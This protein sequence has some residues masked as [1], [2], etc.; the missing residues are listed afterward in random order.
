MASV[1]PEVKCGVFIEAK[2]A[3]GEAKPGFE[4]RLDVTYR[5]LPQAGLIAL[6][7][8]TAALIDRMASYGEAAAAGK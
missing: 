7:K 1:L 4:M 6:E 3:E 8:E 2:F 5:N